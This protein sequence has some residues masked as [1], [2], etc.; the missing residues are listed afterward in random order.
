[1]KYL[2]GTFI[3]IALTAP[4]FAAEKL[5]SDGT[6]FKSSDDSA[7]AQLCLA[8]L[9]S[10]EALNHKARELKISRKTLQKVSCNELSLVEFVKNHRDDMREWAIATVQ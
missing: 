8:A 7:A 9:E 1:M 3:V 4:T 5:H 10:R 6:V 2:I